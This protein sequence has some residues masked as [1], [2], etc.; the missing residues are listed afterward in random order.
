MAL[1]FEL[2]EF[3]ARRERLLAKMAE[4]KL[5][6]LLLFAQESMYWLTGYDTFGYCFFQ[7]LVVKSDGSMTLLTRS[8]DLRQAR[9]TSIIENIQIWADRPNADPTLDLKNLLSDLDLL[10]AKI[11]VE[12]DTHGMTGRVARLLDNQLAS[13]CQMSD[14]SYL[15]S[16]LRLVKSPAEIAHAR[17]AGQLADAALDA[18]L[19]LI[20]PGADEAAILAAMQGAV[21]AGGGDY[22]ANEFIV[23]SGADALLCRYKAGRRRLDAKDQLTLEWAGVSAH[24]HAAMMR[25]VVI[26]EQDFRQKEL[27]SACLQNLTAIEEVLRPGKTFGDVFDVHARVMD[28]RGLTRHRLNSCGYSLGA[29]FSPSWMEHQ[30]FHTGNPQEI[31]ADMTL[32]VHMIVMDSDSGTA[33]TLGQTYLTTDGAPEPLSRH[34]LDLLTA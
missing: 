11:G 4:E 24:Y 29:R 6:A 17:K 31:T 21:L 20:R 19:P 8:A 14:A 16:T 5:D 3:D 27:Y 15:V 7:T 12:Y 1:H 10:G 18:A 26:G 9:N 30:M 22:P 23:G 28:E 34:N 2:S 32:F 25:T 33:M 13:F